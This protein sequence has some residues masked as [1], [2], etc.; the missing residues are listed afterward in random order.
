MPG[1]S[2]DSGVELSGPGRLRVTSQ[3]RRLV[4]GAWS[5]FRSCVPARGIVKCARGSAA[6]RI[7]FDHNLR[8]RNQPRATC[9]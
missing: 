5:F 2:A 8:R 7:G 1:G 4:I 3:V 6:L 9:S